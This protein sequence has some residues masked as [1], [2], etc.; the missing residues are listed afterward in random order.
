MR[1]YLHYNGKYTKEKIKEWQELNLYHL[2]HE[3]E[4]ALDFWFKKIQEKKE[5]RV[6]LIK[7]IAEYGIEKKIICEDY[8]IECEKIDEFK[9]I[10]EIYKNKGFHFC[11]DLVEKS[12]RFS[13]LKKMYGSK[14]ARPLRFYTFSK[15]VVDRFNQILS[16]FTQEERD[17]IQKE[18]QSLIDEKYN[19]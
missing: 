2:T 19:K 17:D 3:E 16:L 6:K 10:Y 18:Y 1:K 9:K 5:D 13:K 8:I 4:E 15:E 7:E 12:E 11:L 14:F